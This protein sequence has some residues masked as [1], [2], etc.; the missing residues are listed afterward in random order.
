M[1]YKKGAKKI[2]DFGVKIVAVKL[3]KQGCYITDGK[4]SHFLK[5]YN[6][7]AIDTT[8]AGVQF[9]ATAGNAET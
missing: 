9:I 1:D 3:G 4:E 6:V 8:G 7:D 2:L 5:A